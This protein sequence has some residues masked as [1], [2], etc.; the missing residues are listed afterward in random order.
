MPDLMSLADNVLLAKAICFRAKGSDSCNELEVSRSVRFEN[1]YMAACVQHAHN[2]NLPPVLHGHLGKLL[3]DCGP[4]FSGKSSG[5]YSRLKKLREA[6]KKPVVFKYLGETE[7]YGATVGEI[8]G[9]GYVTLHSGEKIEAINIKTGA[10]IE[11]WLRNY[12]GD[13][14]FI[15][16]D[17]AQFPAGLYDTTLSLLEQGKQVNMN[18]LV[19]T[20]NRTG[21][22]NAPTLMCLAD[23]I[24]Y[25]TA[26]CVYEGC[27]R[28]ATES[29]RMVVRA[30][31]K[32]IQP[33][34]VTDPIEMIA[35]SD[36]N[37]VHESEDRCFYRAACLP[38]LQLP[39]EEVNRFSFEK[40]VA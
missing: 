23:E 22:M 39:G 38:H 14:Q 12:Q 13:T 31:S 11:E 18:H 26:T 37:E 19:R 28:P 17:E 30:G 3:L 35:G 15:F 7:R 25:N 10:D 27:G 9:S 33:A 29:Q 36:P 32:I 8:F 6:G 21:F 16:I 34:L 24:N 5:W 1:K 4:M 2:P 40:Y 20:F